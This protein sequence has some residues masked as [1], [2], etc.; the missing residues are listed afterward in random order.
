MHPLDAMN[1]VRHAYETGGFTTRSD[2]FRAHTEAVAQ[3]ACLGLLT[4]QGPDGSFGKVWRLTPLGLTLLFKDVPQ[5]NE[6]L[7]QAAA[8]PVSD[9]ASGSRIFGDTYTG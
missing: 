3:A 9:R 7:L 6:T 8:R 2:Y 4:T 5:F 1:A